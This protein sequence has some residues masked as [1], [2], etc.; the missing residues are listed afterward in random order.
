MIPSLR[1]GAGRLAKLV[2]LLVFPSFCRLCERPLEEAG[3]RIVCGDC[4]AKLAPRRG[5]SCPGC[6][7]FLEGEGEGHPCARCLEEAPACSIHR[8]SGAY[9]GTLKDVILLFK[10]RKCA[11]LSRPLARYMD[12]CLASEPGLWEG[13]EF[14]VPVP[15]HPSRRRERGF[16]QARLLA[17][18]LAAL[19]GLAVLTGALVKTRNAPAQAGLRAADRERNARGAYA[20]RRPERVRDRTLVL[21][22][23][24]TTT[25]ATIRECARVLQKAGARDVRAVTLAQA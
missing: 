13:A 7:R 2:E 12:S 8:S 16:N 19:R 18:D 24:V 3:E 6:G 11:P 21:V 15:L 22:D 23:D 14:L 10:Y 1:A 9:A 17:R 4:L 5:P 25:G 20:V